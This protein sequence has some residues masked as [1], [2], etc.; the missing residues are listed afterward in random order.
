MLR[1]M[2]MP[3]FSAFVFF[4]VFLSIPITKVSAQ[5][6]ELRDIFAGTGISHEDLEKIEEKLGYLTPEQKVIIRDIFISLPKD[7]GKDFIDVIVNLPDSA[8]SQLIRIMDGMTGYEKIRFVRDL[9]NLPST[10]TRVLFIRRKFEAVEE[11]GGVSLIERFY[12]GTIVEEE[13]L[14][15]QVGYNLSWMRSG[16]ISPQFI[17]EGYILGPGDSIFI[18]IWGRTRLPESLNFPVRVTVLQDGKI[19]IPFAGPVAVGGLTIRE[20]GKIIRGAVRK[21]LGN[22]EVAVS[23]SALKSIPIVVMG[24]VGNPGVVVLSG[25]LTPFDAIS[26]AGGIKKT[27]TLRRIEIKRGG[28][29]IAEIDLYKLIFKGDIQD[30]EKI[31]L[32]SWDMV[33]V[34]KI[35][36]TFAI[37]GAV[38][39]EGIYEIGGEE[40]KL[41]LAEA[42]ELA[43]GTLPDRGKFRI[44]IKRFFGEKRKV[45]FDKII[46][47]EELPKH[48]GSIYII[49]S[50]L[51]EVFPA[52]FEVEE[53]Y[54]IISGYVKNPKKIPWFQGMTLKD[55][56][57]LAGGFQNIFPPSAYEITRREEKTTNENL[58]KS[59]KN[60]NGEKRAVT[61]LVGKSIEEIFKLFEKVEILPF[62]RI[63]IIPPAKEDIVELI[64]VEV[65]GEVR[66]PG[67]YSIVEGEKLYDVLRR[68]GG[69]TEEAFP[70]GV[71]FTR[72]SVRVAQQ[73]KVNLIMRLLAKELL[74]EATTGY[75]PLGQIREQLAL[76]R[77][78]AEERLRVL[79]YISEAEV[80][81]RIVIKIPRT[82]EEL[83]NSP[84][85]IELHDGDKIF[86]PRIPKFVMVS[87]E[88]KNPSTF[89]F[90]EG[91][92]AD[93]YINL[94]GGFSKFADDDNI[95]VI[96]ANGE[97]STNL[98]DIGP[99]DSIIVPPK[100]TLPYQSWYLVRDILSLTFQGISATALMYNAVK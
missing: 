60:K 24:E 21:I 41:T 69:F 93:F 27:G 7:L 22:V 39:Q 33:F 10:E 49:N 15:R 2:S 31:R 85:N 75:T 84:Y 38:K 63:V 32:R 81:G 28:R 57:L 55:V 88:V 30:I 82:L 67:I 51:I 11:L 72:E 99:G 89:V 43:G 16:G 29:K 58:G 18:Y 50:D 78:L 46:P 12:S 91:E 73:E 92:D 70:E 71:V 45:V 56:V 79:R 97:T 80:K 13:R 1:F 23:L 76:R 44:R 19:F 34:P 65:I 74:G 35:G 42:I 25:T 5:S 68:A 47:I 86:I 17:S 6:L 66:Y 40:G 77:T 100:I 48:T 87:G 59:K 37:R 53:K 90:V 61:K 94:A 98:S 14:L 8:V 96:K 4:L 83:K 64:T 3:S 20:A 54:I 9:I 62:D 95:Y 26:S 36:P 52:N